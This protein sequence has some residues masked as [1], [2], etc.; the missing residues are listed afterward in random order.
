MG[1][2]NVLYD[3]LMGESEYVMVTDLHHKDL[4]K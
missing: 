2:S 4:R 3:M 1:R